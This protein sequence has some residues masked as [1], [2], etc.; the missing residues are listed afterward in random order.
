MPH[1]RSP[2]A[3]DDNIAETANERLTTQI[4][5]IFLSW[6]SPCQTISTT[7]CL[8]LILSLIWAAADHLLSELR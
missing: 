5:I 6:D 3:K 1:Q 8:R 4:T 7:L 2:M